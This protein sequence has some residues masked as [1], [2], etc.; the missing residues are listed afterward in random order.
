MSEFVI[1]RMA[2]NRTDESEYRSD[3]AIDTRPVYRLLGSTDHRRWTYAETWR[4]R[5]RE[6]ACYGEKAGTEGAL[7]TIAVAELSA[8]HIA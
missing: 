4:E 7:G 1:S 2:Q 3:I 6:G 5:E 8:N